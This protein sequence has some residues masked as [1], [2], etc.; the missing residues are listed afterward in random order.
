MS[1]VGC[2]EITVNN[3]LMVQPIKSPAY[4]CEI[5]GGGERG[6]VKYVCAFSVTPVYQK[7][8][9]SDDSIRHHVSS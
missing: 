2:L 7:C 6:G 8:N 4:I 3:G 5:K 9:N 1:D